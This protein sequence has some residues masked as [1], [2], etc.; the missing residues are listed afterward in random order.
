MSDQILDKILDELNLAKQER[1]DFKSQINNR[2]DILD[3]KMSTL[4]QEVKD[5]KTS[6][7]WIVKTSHRI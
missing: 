4:E 3:T 7:K 6:V 5:I 2:F 1:Q